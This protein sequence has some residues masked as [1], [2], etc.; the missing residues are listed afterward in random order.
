MLEIYS[1]LNPKVANYNGTGG[2]PSLTPEDVSA[3]L[4]LIPIT[5][6]ALLVR[7]MSGEPAVRGL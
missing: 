7:T 3:S 1:L 5:G 4:A 2:V 6:P